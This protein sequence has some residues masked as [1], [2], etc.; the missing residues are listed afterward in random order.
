MPITA[1]NYP[2]KEDLKSILKA[3]EI[4]AKAKP[5]ERVYIGCF[6]GKHRTGILIAI[7]LFLHL[8]KEDKQSIYAYNDT[9]KDS[10]FKPMNHTDDKSL[11]TSNMS[12]SFRKFYRDF[13][14][15]IGE[16]HSQK[17]IQKLQSI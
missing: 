9:G 16:E 1:K 10:A 4:L 5:S 13:T 14:D 7:Y 11:I 2:I 3:L 8:Y 12:S 17:F 6:F 15:P